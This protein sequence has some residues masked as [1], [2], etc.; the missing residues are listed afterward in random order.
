MFID[1]VTL[2][3]I[4]MAAGFF[5]LAAYLA[6]GIESAQPTRWV[7]AFAAVGLVAVLNGLPMI[8][9]WPLPGPFNMAFGE[10]SLLFGVLFL[11]TALSLAKDWDL[12]FLGVYALFAGMAA[13]LIGVRIVQLGLTREPAL[14]GLGFILSGASGI[15]AAPALSLRTRRTLR[16]AAS[17]VLLT[18]ALIWA[19]TGYKAY[20][21]HMESF[22]GW[23]PLT[24]QAPEHP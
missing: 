5:L 23:T 3:L 21:E 13:L 9:L 17:L 4:N 18:A 20:W 8:H 15:L 22:A 2:L 10:M 7:A 11:G 24:V 19:R 16:M 14:A 12:F 6:T 1:Y